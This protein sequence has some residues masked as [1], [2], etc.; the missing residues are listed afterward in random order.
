MVH[1]GRITAK[2]PKCSPSR[3]HLFLFRP[4]PICLFSLI[5]NEKSNITESKNQNVT[6]SK[7]TVTFG[8]LPHTIHLVKLTHLFAFKFSHSATEQSRQQSRPFI[9]AT[10]CIQVTLFAHSLVGECLKIVTSQKRRICSF[11]IF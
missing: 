6:K 10:L 2:E 5:Q 9:K 3:G 4:R 8:V 11:S 1:T 7:L